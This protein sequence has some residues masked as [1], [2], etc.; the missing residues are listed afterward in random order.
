MRVKKRVIQTTNPLVELVTKDVPNA[1]TAAVFRC[2]KGHE[3]ESIVAEINRSGKLGSSRCPYCINRKT[4][5]GYNDIATTHPLLANSVTEKSKHLLTTERKQSEK[6][7]EV[8]CAEG[9]VYEKQ[10]FRLT[11][12]ID[13]GH[14]SLCCEIC[15]N[16]VVNE[17]NDMRLK[18]PVL[19]SMLV[20]KN[21]AEKHSVGSDVRTEFKCT[22]GHIFISRINE[23]NRTLKNG[24]GSKGCPQCSQDSR[25]SGGEKELFKYV[26]NLVGKDCTVLKNSRKLIYPYELD[27]YIPELNIAIE[28]NGV[29]WHSEGAGKEKDYHAKKWELCDKKN[30]QLL[31]IWEDDWRDRKNLIKK[32]LA[33]KLGVSKER[34]IYARDTYVNEI[35]RTTAKDFCKKNY[36]LEF[37]P[38]K[39]YLG[40]FDKENDE[41]VAV[42]VWKKVKNELRFQS[43][44]TS[45]NI[46]GGAGKILK[47]AKEK[48]AELKCVS[49][50]AIVDKDNSNGKMYE[51]LGFER[52]KDLVPSCTYLRKS[53]RV[54]KENLNQKRFKEDSLFNYKDGLSMKELL[55]LNNMRRIWNAGRIYYEMKL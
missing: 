53:T 22:K 26:K 33:H 15:T 28:Y 23:L 51:K 12:S 32:M 46:P 52:H 20:D 31:T 10:I 14:T 24:S 11:K 42:S 50:F 27:I 29:F 54:S 6:I 41:L 3:F 48:A 49:L 9:H 39:F 34:K 37:S 35:N 40:L 45:V 44:C 5:A 38:G 4:L 13:R 43:Y 8:K 16:Q 55:K 25:V 2:L 18:N 17:S 21:L 47:T 7:V 30:V 36:I 19:Y 1:S